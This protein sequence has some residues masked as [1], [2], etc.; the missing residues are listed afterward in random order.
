MARMV[1]RGEAGCGTTVE[2]E[3]DAAL[4]AGEAARPE[5][6]GSA[7][8]TCM[9]L[10]AIV[11]TKQKYHEL[12]L[13]EDAPRLDLAVLEECAFFASPASRSWRLSLIACSVSRIS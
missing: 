1:I 4:R 11:S 2:L 10:S 9:Y 13:D 8:L 12:T 6:E 7:I 5:R 3:V